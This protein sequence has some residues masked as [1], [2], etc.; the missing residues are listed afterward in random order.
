MFD[1]DPRSKD[2]P[3][4]RDDDSR[5]RDS[6]DPEDAFVDKLDLPR[7]SCIEYV[8]PLGLAISRSP[9]P[10]LLIAIV[11]APGW[12]TRLTE[13]LFRALHSLR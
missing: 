11:Y 7:A 13:N 2:D 4:Q 12:A 5:D 3:R 9:L 8:L 1:N 6:V 10:T